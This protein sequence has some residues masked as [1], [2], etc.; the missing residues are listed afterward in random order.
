MKVT[1]YV[2]YTVILKKNKTKNLSAVA[3]TLKA[4]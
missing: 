2:D 1:L 3:K 4:F